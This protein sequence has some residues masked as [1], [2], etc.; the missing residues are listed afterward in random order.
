M[1]F[2]WAFVG[3]LALVTGPIYSAYVTYALGWS[4]VLRIPTSIRSQLTCITR[5]WVFYMSTIIAGIAFICCLF[6]KE[7]RPSLL[8]ERK[9]AALRHSTAHTS[10]RTRNPD[11]APNLKTFIRMFLI[12]PIY[13]LFTEPIISTISIMGSIVVATLYPFVEALP[14]IYGSFGFSKQQATLAFIPI[15]LGLF[16]GVFTRLHDQRTLSKL[17]SKGKA[18]EPENKLF[19]F[20]IAAPALAIAFWWF[21]WTVPPHGYDSHWIVSM[22]ALVPVGFALNEF[23]YTLSGYLADS[24]TI[25]AASAFAGLLL[26]RSFATAAILPF[27][28]QMYTNLGTNLASSVMATVATAFCL[29]PFVLIRYGKRIRKASKFARFSLEVYRDNQVGDDMNV[30]LAEMVVSDRS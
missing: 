22:L 23:L 28:P 9:V 3:I 29:A 8:L 30:A 26:S 7:S 6:I 21:A 2:M 10:F 17:R 5:R 27:T 19:G 14:I 15:G 1:I 18:I 13:L 24:Y 11:A 25:Y 20:A 16:F 4:V 12:R